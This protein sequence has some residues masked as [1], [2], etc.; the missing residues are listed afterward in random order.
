MGMTGLI[1]KMYL[2]ENKQKLNK[3]FSKKIDS[4]YMKYKEIALLKE[5]LIKLKPERC[6]EYGCGYSSLFYP[7]ILT[8]GATWMSVEHNE[9]W[10]SEI[11]K[12]NLNK[13]V[14]IF[15]INA[16]NM[17]FI[18]EGEY[19][20][21][22]SYVNFPESKG[23]FDF[24]LIDGMARKACIEKA[25]TLLSENGVIVVHD[26]NRSAYHEE[27]K[28][29]TNWLILEDYR[30]TAGGL[31]L[32]TNKTLIQDLF[33]VNKHKKIW[34]IDTRISNFL[35]LK[36][37]ILKTGKPFNFQISSHASN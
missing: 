24:I 33:D 37:L 15:H 29:Y 4:P 18:D 31:G 34:E 21:F 3:L 2:K 22:S 23:K 35:K 11:T 7:K 26:S 10:Y 30:K 27:I 6:L 36:F 5:L 1:V 25:K 16:N 9:Q 19:K 14:E 20:D 8:K 28:K 32:A 13:N 12:K 17:N